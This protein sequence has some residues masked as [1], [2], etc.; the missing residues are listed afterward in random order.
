MQFRWSKFFIFCCKIKLHTR[1]TEAGAR[2]YTDSSYNVATRNIVIPCVRDSSQSKV[3]MKRFFNFPYQFALT[4]SYSWVK[5]REREAMSLHSM[6]LL[7]VITI[8]WPLWLSLEPFNVEFRAPIGRPSCLKHYSALKLQIS[9]GK[10]DKGSSC[11]FFGALMKAVTP[12][13]SVYFREAIED[14]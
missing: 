4:C 2:T 12:V 9:L 11:S 8:Q 13:S 10:S 6:G 1:L 7:P 3:T 14:G 5:G